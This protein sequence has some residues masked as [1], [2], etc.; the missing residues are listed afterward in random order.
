MEGTASLMVGD[1]GSICCFSWIEP[2]ILSSRIG[3]MRVSLP[4]LVASKEGCFRLEPCRMVTGCDLVSASGSSRGSLS[5]D[6]T[7]ANE[8]TLAERAGI[9]T[10]LGRGKVGVEVE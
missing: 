7:D 9:S 2:T 10:F 5:S 6:S 3:V 1:K 4:R 8:S